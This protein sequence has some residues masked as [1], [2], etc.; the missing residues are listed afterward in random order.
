MRRRELITILGSAAVTLR[1][2]ARAQQV[3]QIRR[4]GVLV[5]L[6]EGDPEG[7]SDIAGLG[8]P[9]L[10]GSSNRDDGSAHSAIAEFADLFKS[11]R[12]PQSASV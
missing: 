9:H 1:L 2:N 5:G 10:R 11:T 6:A 4:V 12:R 3:D 7:K 8:E